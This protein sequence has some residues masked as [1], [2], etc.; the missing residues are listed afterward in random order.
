MTGSTSRAR[1]RGRQTTNTFVYMNIGAKHMLEQAEQPQDG[2]LYTLTSSLVFSAFTLEAYLN[3]LGALKHSN[4]DEIERR[5]G[6]RR[7]YEMLAQ[8]AGLQIDFNRRPY[9]TLV[10]LFAFR[11]RMAHGRTVTEDVSV[12]IDVTAPRLPQITND[13]DWQALATIENARAAIEDVEALVRELH[14]G[15]GYPR[16]PFASAGGG[17]YGVTPEA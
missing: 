13:S 17:F 6:K 12:L 10:E 14:S 15:S 16:N 1:V 7:K 4:W 3:H 2:Q 8:E 5:Y 11:D 9:R